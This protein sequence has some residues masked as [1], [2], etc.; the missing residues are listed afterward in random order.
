MRIRAYLEGA[1][2][3]CVCVCVGGG[4]GGGEGI[5]IQGVKI[6]QPVKMLAFTINNVS[7]T[8]LGLG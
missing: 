8:F 7:L 6:F 5:K 1:S 3:V 2:C 4:G